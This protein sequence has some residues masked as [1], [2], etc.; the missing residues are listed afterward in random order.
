[1]GARESV[2]GLLTGDS[3]LSARLAIPAP[4]APS[5]VIF[6]GNAIDSPESK[7]FVVLRWEER[8]RTFDGIGARILTI[9]AHDLSGDYTRVDSI[10]KRIRDLFYAVEHLGP[11]SQ[12][13]WDG[14]S[15]DLY[16]TGFETITRNS[17]FRVIGGTE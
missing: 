17:G 10:L 15:G 8:T 3:I 7:P 4:L 1:M 12:I 11:V 9:W 2:Y 16:D 5:D 14:D 13:F 6:S